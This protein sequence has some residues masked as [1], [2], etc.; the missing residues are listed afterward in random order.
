MPFPNARDVHQD[1]VLTNL[2]VQYRNEEYIAAQCVPKVLVRKASDKYYEFDQGDW[3]RDEA[4]ERAAATT[5]PVGGYS[6]STQSY[7]TKQF[8]MATYVADEERDNADAG[9]DLDRQA[10]EY[11]A[12]KVQLRFETQAAGL[13]FKAGSYPTGHKKTLS[14]AAQWSDASSKPI[15]DIRAAKS[16]VGGAI[17]RQ[18]NTLILGEQTYLQLQDHPDVLDR[19]KYTQSGAVTPDLLAGLFDVNRV[20]VGRAV[21]NTAAEG[22]DA[23]YARVWGKHAALIYAAPMP[24]LRTLSFAYWF[25]WRGYDFTAERWRKS[26]GGASDGFRVRAQWDSKIAAKTAGYFIE[27]AVA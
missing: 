18:P 27:N 14:G 15:A 23:S 2:S 9:L 7:D 13:L 17:G 12:D 6:L 26:D 22:L 16:Q 4:G 10:I 25:V 24:G 11:C 20:L 5:G 8:S 21:Q 3:F 1:S 19:V